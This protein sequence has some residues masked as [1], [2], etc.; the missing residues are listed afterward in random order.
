MSLL[1]MLPSHALPMTEINS[2]AITAPM[3]TTLPREL[4]VEDQRQDNW[5]WAAVATSLAKYYDP[6]TP[7]TQ[8]TVA[9]LELDRDDCQHSQTG[10]TCDKVRHLENVLKKMGMLAEWPTKYALPVG[11]VRKD[12][13]QGN[14]V[15]IRIGWRDS[16]GHYAVIVAISGDG[17]DASYYVSDP[18]YDDGICSRKTLYG[19]YQGQGGGWNESFRTKAGRQP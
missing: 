17:L 1:S 3:W 7:W 6:N 18:M 15:G 13:E 10:G 4:V 16:K 12:I 11:S 8:E 19:N 5:C 9:N 2:A 14:P